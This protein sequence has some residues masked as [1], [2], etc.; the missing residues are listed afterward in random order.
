MLSRLI[1]IATLS[2]VAA[3]G[4]HGANE[5]HTYKR[6]GARDKDS[7]RKAPGTHRASAAELALRDRIGRELSQKLAGTNSKLASVPATSWVSVGPTDA[8]QEFNSV[9]IN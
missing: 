9:V 2:T 6:F 3:I 8:D 7:R 1:L 4:L 5:V